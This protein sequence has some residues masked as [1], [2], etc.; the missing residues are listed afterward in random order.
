MQNTE[1]I[2]LVNTF[3]LSALSIASL[4]ISFFLKD[5]YRDYKEQVGQV[6]RLH[7]ELDT[8]RRLFEELRLLEQQKTDRLQSR[9]DRLEMRNDR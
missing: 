1:M 3:L 2:S 5:L 8:H 9:L 6:N 4:L 7:R